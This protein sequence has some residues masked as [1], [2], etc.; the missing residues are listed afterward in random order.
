M[1]VKSD[2]DRVKALLT[3]A[4][5][6]LCKKRLSFKSQLSVEG[7]IGITLDSDDI[8]LVSIKELILKGEEG[9]E[10]VEKQMSIPVT[11]TKVRS[12]RQRK[13][14]PRHLSVVS[15][16]LHYHVN[17]PEVEDEE[18]ECTWQLQDGTDIDDLSPVTHLHMPEQHVQG[19]TTETPN[20]VLENGTDAPL[21]LSS[22]SSHTRPVSSQTSLKQEEK[23]HRDITP[24]KRKRHD[25]GDTDSH[26]S[27]AVSGSAKRPSSVSN[28]SSLSPARTT[29]TL[30]LVAIKQEPKTEPPFNNNQFDPTTN[31]YLSIQQIHDK[32]CSHTPVSK[33]FGNGVMKDTGNILAGR[34]N[35][36]ESAIWQR[37]ASPI[38]PIQLTSPMMPSQV[39]YV[40]YFLFFF[41]NNV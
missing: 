3:E 30:E 1:I 36:I 17:Y 9:E 37:L 15:P 38:T 23:P 32:A 6:V 12:G 21:N 28:M 4:I 13:S 31:G 40:F 8:F 25:S 35:L 27:S 22:N 19:Y 26:C 16:P 7:L 33:G 10:P 41:N 5:T 39:S 2:Q 14:T 24:Q 20:V 29:P 34:T 11:S 18:E